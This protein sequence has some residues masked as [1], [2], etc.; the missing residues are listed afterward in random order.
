MPTHQVPQKENNPKLIEL[1]NSKEVEE[2]KQWCKWAKLFYR[3]V[4][5]TETNFNDVLKR[6]EEGYLQ[7]N[8]KAQE[9]LILTKKTANY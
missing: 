4:L 1:E 8:P 5:P 9:Y 7:T 3:R 2:Y 6:A